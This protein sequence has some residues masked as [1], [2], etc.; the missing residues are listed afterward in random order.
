MTS[1]S[2]IFALWDSRIHIYSSNG[3]NVVFNVETSVNKFFGF[4]SI[5]GAPNIY[6][7]DYYVLFWES[8]D[9][10]RTKG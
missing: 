2:A 3:Y 10:L 7:Y 1:F 8:F 5:L 6:S 9:N 4:S